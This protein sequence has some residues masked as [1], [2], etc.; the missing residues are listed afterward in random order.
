M[1]TIYKFIL[2]GCRKIYSKVFKIQANKPSGEQDPEKAFEIVYSAL[3]SDQPCMLARFGSTEMACMCNYVGVKQADKPIFKFIKGQAF[4]W[5]WETNIVNQMQQWSGFFPPQ[6]NKIEQFSELMLTD[7]RYVDILGSWLSHEEVFKK[8]LNATKIHLRFLE[9]FWSETPWTKALE[10]KKVL[11]V[12]PFEKSIYKQY[13]NRKNL[14][15]NPD[16]LPGFKSLTV[17]KAVQ[18]LGEAD[19]RFKDWF[20]ALDYMKNEI[21][22]L[23][24]DV[25]L[26]GAGAYGFHLAA[27]VKRKGKKGIHIGGALQLLFGIKGKRW[28]DPNYGVNAWAIPT[29]FYSSMMNEHWIRPLE[30]ETPKNANSVEGACYW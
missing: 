21:D 9:P 6:I 15:K 13:H 29:G 7:M 3:N 5:W 19:D 18:S 10:G 8:E 22:K 27:H 16:V 25:C 11:V 12:H 24:Y 26:I 2:K 28:E 4:P 30:D 1:N 23:D 20:E 14:F 17:I